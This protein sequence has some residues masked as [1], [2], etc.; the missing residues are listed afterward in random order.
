MQCDNDGSHHR[1]TKRGAQLFALAP[2][3][4][5]ITA[6]KAASGATVPSMISKA[7]QKIN[8]NSKSTNNP[9]TIV[10]TN[11]T[12]APQRLNQDPSGNKTG[13]PQQGNAASGNPR[14]A[15]QVNPL[16][17]QG[18]VRGMTGIFSKIINKPNILKNPQ[19]LGSIVGGAVGSL[20]EPLVDFGKNLINKPPSLPGM[21]NATML[22]TWFGFNGKGENN[23]ISGR[24][25]TGA[26]EKSTTGIPLS[27]ADSSLFNPSLFNNAQKTAAANQ[28]DAS[29]PKYKIYFHGQELTSQ[30]L[31][32]FQDWFNKKIHLDSSNVV[33]KVKDENGKLIANN[34]NLQK[35]GTNY[36]FAGGQSA[37]SKIS[38]EQPKGYLIIGSDGQ[39][40]PISFET[41]K[42]FGK[43]WQQQFGG[44]QQIYSLDQSST[45]RDMIDP[46]KFL[47]HVKSFGDGGQSN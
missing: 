39:P 47:S 27:G 46:A 2:D 20:T 32:K 21:L 13:A 33:F 38:P 37:F 25:S 26:P 40:H 19:A 35:L 16:L 34:I 28:T 45:T 31:N 12:G 43:N 17:L 9:G 29:G 24:T 8:V 4:A 11:N 3:K 10:A 6:G 14:Y 44:V 7:Q 42:K 30:E 5:D 18:M 22:P 41:A 1:N 23:T 36:G 15:L